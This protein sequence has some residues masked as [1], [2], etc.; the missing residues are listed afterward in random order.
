MRPVL[1]IEVCLVETMCSVPFIVDFLLFEVWDR[2]QAT[3]TPRNT[4][5]TQST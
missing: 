3:D 2:Q 5:K 4:H 1:Y